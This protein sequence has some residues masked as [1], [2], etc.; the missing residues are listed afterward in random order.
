MAR[1][2]VLIIACL[3]LAGC[4][5]LT[6]TRMPFRDKKCTNPNQ[7]SVAITNPSCTSSGC[8]ASVD[9][10]RVIFERGRNNFKITWTLPAGY[11]FCDTAG[12]GVFLKKVDPTGQ[13]DIKGVDKP[14]G[15]GPCK[16]KEF[17]LNAKNTRSLPNEPYEYRILFHNEAGTQLYV[18]DPLMVNE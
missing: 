3:T 10:D 17:Q 8:S 15:T 18:V 9:F 13:F 4:A 5:T 1:L 16:M 2:S 12:D 6:D 11:G 14:E 7:C